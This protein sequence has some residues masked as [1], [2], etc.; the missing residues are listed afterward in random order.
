MICRF[1]DVEAWVNTASLNCCLDVVVV[2]VAHQH[3]R[4][5]AQARHRLVRRVGL[6]HA[7]P[8]LAR[9]RAR[10]A[11]RAAASPWDRGRRRA[12]CACAANASAAACGL[13]RRLDVGGRAHGRARPQER[14]EAREAEPRL[15]PQEDEVRLDREQLLHHAARVVDVAVEGAVGEGDQPHP[16]E[17]AGGLELEQ[18]LLERAQRHRRRTSSRRSSGTPRRSTAARPPSPCRSGATCGSCGR[19]WRCRPAPAAP[20]RPSC[21]TSTCRW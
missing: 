5:L 13:E 8:D 6:V 12:F 14:R 1:G 18:R 16:V 2:V 11:C 21:S 4:A 10:G 20:A 9:D 19:R 7:Q 15:V 3:H 17:P